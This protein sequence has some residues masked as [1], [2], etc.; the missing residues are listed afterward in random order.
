MYL[1]RENGKEGKGLPGKVPSARVMG[2][3]SLT[4]KY[5]SLSVLLVLEMKPI[6]SGRGMKRIPSPSQSDPS[7]IPNGL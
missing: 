4:L 6:P 7:P 1:D 3:V 2:K 5:E